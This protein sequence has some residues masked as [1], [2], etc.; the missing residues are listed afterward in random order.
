M[1]IGSLNRSTVGANFPIGTV[2]GINMVEKA[3]E[4]FGVKK[5]SPS[6]FMY[7]GIEA[8]PG[9]KIRFGKEHP[10]GIIPQTGYINFASVFG[11][12]LNM[13]YLELDT[14]GAF[15]IFFQMS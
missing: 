8:L 15:N 1:I 9:A 11:N 12:N 2:I 6:K 13:T 10:W 4:L 3:K 14:D 7:G 5:D